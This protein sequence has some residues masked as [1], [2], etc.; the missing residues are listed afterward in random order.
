MKAFVYERYGPPET[1]RMAEVDTPA[2]G[3]DEVLVKVL[4]ASVNAADWHLLRGAPALVEPGEPEH[5]GEA[6]RE[7]IDGNARDDLVALEGDRGDG[8]QQRHDHGH[9]DAGKQAEPDTAGEH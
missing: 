3:A 8:M 9:G 5:S 4:G 7:E 2:P 6:L 1:L